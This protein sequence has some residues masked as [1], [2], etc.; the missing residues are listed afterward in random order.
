VYTCVFGW[1][2]ADFSWL[3]LAFHFF[4]RIKVGKSICKFFVSFGLRLRARTPP[5][6]AFFTP[7]IDDFPLLATS[8]S[9]QYFRPHSHP[10]YSNRS[11]PP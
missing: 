7:F 6:S 9:D 8:N 3:F 11:T 5:I 2:S 10:P 1:Y 4:I